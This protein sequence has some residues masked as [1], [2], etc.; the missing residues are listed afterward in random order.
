MCIRF[1]L[2]KMRRFEK[3]L[4]IYRIRESLTLKY[5]KIII[6]KKDRWLDL[7]MFNNATNK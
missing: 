4:T 6:V 3:I 7:E 2:L 5:D 1:D